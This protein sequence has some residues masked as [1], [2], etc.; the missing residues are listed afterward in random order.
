MI[1]TVP[2][3]ARGT[4]TGKVHGH[5]RRRLADTPNG[6]TVVVLESRLQRPVCPNLDYPPQ[7]FLSRS[8]G[9][10]NGTAPHTPS[11]ELLA[12]FAITL[13]GRAASSP[14][15]TTGA[16]CQAFTATPPTLSSD[17]ASDGTLKDW[18]CTNPISQVTTV[19]VAFHEAFLD[20]VAHFDVRVRRSAC[21]VDLV[22][23]W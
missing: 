5:H 6:G 4:M 15:A 19:K 21:A 20:R 18:E 11:A 3:P 8:L 16:C 23:G 1:G 14:L 12:S 17:S 7:N 2:C 22:S 10:P 9:W 13:A